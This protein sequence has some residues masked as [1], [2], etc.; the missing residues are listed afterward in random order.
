ML[1]VSSCLVFLHIEQL[2]RA[3]HIHFHIV[4]KF[5][6]DHLT[7][8]IDSLIVIHPVEALN[9]KTTTATKVQNMGDGGGKQKESD[10]DLEI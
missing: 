10:G 7:L 4:L 2:S 9:T 6:Y 8:V 1:S 5:A 3:W